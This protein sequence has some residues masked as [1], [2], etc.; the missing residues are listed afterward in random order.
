M[1]V[2]D[3]L[4]PAGPVASRTYLTEVRTEIRDEAEH[5]LRSLAPQVRCERLGFRLLIDIYS[6]EEE[7]IVA[8]LFPKAVLISSSL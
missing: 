7:V 3:D 6:D 8:M 1:P 5:T 2:K 4:T